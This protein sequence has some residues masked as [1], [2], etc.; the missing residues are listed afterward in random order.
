MSTEI[1]Q[2]QEELVIYLFLI[3][4]YNLEDDSSHALFDNFGAVFQ[5]IARNKQVRS[6]R[7]V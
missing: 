1:V 4:T 6:L 7:G 3:I 2:K 5:Y